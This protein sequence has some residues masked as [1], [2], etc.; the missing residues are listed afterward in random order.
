M[1]KKNDSYEI[2]IQE[3]K[4]YKIIGPMRA[5]GDTCL[6]QTSRSLMKWRFKVMGC[7]FNL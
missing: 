1:Q 4:S 6:V 7:K 3:T 5:Q 2:F